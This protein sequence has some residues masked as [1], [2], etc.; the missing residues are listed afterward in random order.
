MVSKNPPDGSFIDMPSFKV[1]FCL[2]NVGEVDWPEDTYL[3]LCGSTEKFDFKPIHIPL[4]VGAMIN[5]DFPLR[6]PK[7]RKVKNKY[8][9]QLKSH[10]EFFGDCFEINI[11][12]KYEFNHNQQQQ[13]QPG[14]QN[15][16]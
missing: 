9:F 3:E 6:K 11:S 14:V 8:F 1:M 12:T 7:S 10:G 2:Q 16:Q 4:K 13:Q 15:P 5:V